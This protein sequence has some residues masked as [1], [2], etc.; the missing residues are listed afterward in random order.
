MSSTCVPVADIAGESLREFNSSWD[1]SVS[2]KGVQLMDVGAEVGP[3]SPITQPDFLG[4]SHDPVAGVSPRSK[5]KTS[6]LM[7]EWWR[8]K[9]HEAPCVRGN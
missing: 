4:R 8:S 5:V 7:L 6:E 1:W 9:S 3:V 2:E